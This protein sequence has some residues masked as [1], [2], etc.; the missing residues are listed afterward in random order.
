[1]QAVQEFDR[2]VA[3]IGAKGKLTAEQMTAI[4]QVAKITSSQM[5][6]FA[7]NILKAQDFLVGMGLDFGRATRAMLSIAQALQHHA[8]LLLG[9]MVL[10]ACPADVLHYMLGRRPRLGFLSHLRFSCELR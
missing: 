7:I 1:M 4:D 9:R 3:E 6:Q 8:D 5:N 2:A 10:P